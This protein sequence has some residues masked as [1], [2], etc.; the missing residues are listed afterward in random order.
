MSF[1]T[2]FLYCATVEVQAIALVKGQFTGLNIPRFVSAKSNKINVRRGPSLTYKID[3]VYQQV[4][5]PLKVTA[6]YEHWLKV[7]DYQGEGGW[8]HSRLL[9]GNRFVIFLVNNAR[10]KRKPNLKSPEIALIQKGVIAKL[11][12]VSGKWC[13]VAVGGHVGWSYRDNVWGLLDEENLKN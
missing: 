8:V 13:Q 12:S 3:W 4:G 2:L 7:V 6:E 11:I 9:S 10:L 1:C 5:V